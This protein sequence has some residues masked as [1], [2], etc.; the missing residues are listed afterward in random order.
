M[1]ELKTNHSIS[2]I[3]IAI[4]LC[5]DNRIK[6]FVYYEIINEVVVCSLC[7]VGQ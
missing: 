3:R 6:I 7:K 2:R 5:R 4:Y 1:S